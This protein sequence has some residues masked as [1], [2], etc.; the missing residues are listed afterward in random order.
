MLFRVYIR[1]I[2]LELKFQ[3]CFLIE[4]LRTLPC[5]ECNIKCSYVH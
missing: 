3:Q 2:C 4:V 5:R 1:Y